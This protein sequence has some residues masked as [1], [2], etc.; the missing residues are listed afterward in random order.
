MATNSSAGCWNWVARH[1][2]MTCASWGAFTALATVHSLISR[3]RIHHSSSRNL[4]IMAIASPNRVVPSNTMLIARPLIS[5]A[6]RCCYCSR[7]VGISL[8]RWV[9]DVSR[10]FCSSTGRRSFTLLSGKPAFR[11]CSVTCIR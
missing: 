7:M 8:R 3:C 1:S 2:L 5:D 10:N 9:C 4:T 11:K 6:R